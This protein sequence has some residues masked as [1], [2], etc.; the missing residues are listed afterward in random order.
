L[1]IL[2]AAAHLHLHRAPLPDDVAAA[3][4]DDD[5]WVHQQFARNLADRGRL[6]HAPGVA[7]TGD[8]SPLWTTLIAPAHVAGGP[9]VA[10]VWT[11][12]LSLGAWVAAAWMLGRLV[13]RAFDHRT[14]G[15]A[16]AVLLVNE[17]HLVRASVS[18]METPL[19]VLLMM[20]LLVETL[21][22]RPRARRAGLWG[23]LLFLTRPEAILF[24]GA[25]F[26][27]LMVRSWRAEPRARS[28]LRDTGWA[29]GVAGALALPRLVHTW[30]VDGSFVPASWRA[31]TEWHRILELRWA[32]PDGAP[33][34][35]TRFLADWMHGFSTGMH[36]FLL[37]W[38][39]LG[40]VALGVL[41]V[42]DRRAPRWILP[43]AAAAA[44]IWFFSVRFPLSGEGWRHLAPA[45]ALLVGFS[46]GAFAAIPERLSGR[47]ALGTFAGAAFLTAAV[48]AL[49]A[50][51]DAG[52]DAPVV[53]LARA[54]LLVPA[55]ALGA[56]VLPALAAWLVEGD[57]E[58]GSATPRILSAA[59]V[60]AQ[61]LLGLLVFGLALHA[62]WA[63]LYPADATDRGRPAFAADVA[64]VRVGVEAGRRIA[65][66]AA[67]AG[68][69]R[70][71]VAAERPGAVAFF[72][73]AATIDLRGVLTPTLSPFARDP[74]TLAPILAGH[75]PRSGAI[76]GRY[77][78][79]EGRGID[80]LLVRIDDR[81]EFREVPFRIRRSAPEPI[82]TWATGGEVWKLFRTAGGRNEES[83]GDGG[84]APSRR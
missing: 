41:W 16:A 31:L 4:P 57:E 12:L 80:Y 52:L 68:I 84:R 72:S 66:D 8:L 75:D 50:D 40:L 11:L 30:A 77:G 39:L 47:V 19:F 36:R 18:G 54:D 64:R 83:R 82:E 2:N 6:E 61:R 81:G 76:L 33:G 32:Y 53:R 14:A 73:G 74:A 44:W 28:I 56:T 17:P 48:A 22:E 38:F 60:P 23:G 26:P 46:A 21:A 70:P 67:S 51:L 49:A 29:F 15:I 59:R 42:R 10:V 63:D 43:L 9:A 20:M 1:L 55:A 27:V 45:A 24:V 13:V 79:P 69:A 3:F 65:A 5:A 71:V 62:G 25:C 7:S 58:G 78:V 35:S 34:L 37:P